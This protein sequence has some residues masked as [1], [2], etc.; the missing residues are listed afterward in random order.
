M[1]TLTV[2]MGPPGA[3]KT[4]WTETNLAP[5]QVLCST[6]PI[7]RNRAMHQRQGAI[8]AYLAN[9]RA[10]AETALAEGR[11]AVVDGCNTRRGDRSTWLALARRYRASTRLVVFATSLEAMLAAQRTRTH[12]VADDKVRSYYEEFRRAEVAIRREGWGQIE[13]VRR[14]GI[15][16]R[17]VSNW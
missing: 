13:Y 15:Q 7:R 5:G 11:D 2:L 17:R 6:E 14:T 4:T 10:K 9:L 3:G 16:P 8:V 1:P 12:P